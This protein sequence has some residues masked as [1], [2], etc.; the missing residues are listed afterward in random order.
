MKFTIKD[1][2]KTKCESCVHAF[3]IKAYANPNTLN[4]CRILNTAV[5]RIETCNYHTLITYTQPPPQMLLDAYRIDVERKRVAKVGFGGKTVIEEVVEV[6]SH[7]PP[8]REELFT[9]SLND[10]IDNTS[11]D[12]EEDE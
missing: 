1:Q 8:S 12:S 11:N 4:I 10:P 9:A 2:D 7:E 3:R 6:T 5:G